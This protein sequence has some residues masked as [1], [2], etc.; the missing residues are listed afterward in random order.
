M[1]SEVQKQKLID[2]ANAAEAERLSKR[3][4]IRKVETRETVETLE[5]VEAVETEAGLESEYPDGQSEAVVPAEDEPIAQ[6]NVLQKDAQDAL[7][8]GALNSSEAPR[9]RKR[10][11]KAQIVPEEGDTVT[12][13]AP[14]ALGRQPRTRRLLGAPSGLEISKLS[15]ADQEW[16]TNHPL[17]VKLQRGYPIPIGDQDILALRAFT[18]RGRG[19]DADFTFY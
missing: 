8:S 11:R 3:K 5:T 7:E 10:L 16:L 13:V 2:Q 14:S 19:G 9:K 17:Y 18:P 4:R 15:H 12:A 6:T 1:G